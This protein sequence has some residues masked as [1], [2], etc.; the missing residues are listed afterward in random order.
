MCAPGDLVGLERDVHGH[1]VRAAQNDVFGQS[2]VESW[3]AEGECVGFIGKGLSTLASA[4]PS[5]KFPKTAC[6]ELTTTRGRG[7]MALGI[8]GLAAFTPGLHDAF[9]STSA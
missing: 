9:S 1:G 6:F 2:L 5:A 3:R 7:S 4:A 8:I